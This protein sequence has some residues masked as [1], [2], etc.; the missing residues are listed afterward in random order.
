MGLRACYAM[1]GTDL[2]YGAIGA[3]HVLCHSRYEPHV[4]GYGATRCLVLTLR[5][6][7]AASEYYY[8]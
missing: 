2:A 5:L 7:I 1:P 4:W 6:A 8:Y 3:L